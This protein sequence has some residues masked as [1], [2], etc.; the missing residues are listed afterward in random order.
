[1]FLSG[2]ALCIYVKCGDLT[3]RVLPAGASTLRVL[4]FGRQ[5]A[6]IPLQAK[7]GFFRLP[8]GLMMPHILPIYSDLFTLI[9]E[10]PSHNGI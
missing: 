3:L 9:S 6:S 10:H 2:Q 7:C 8:N 5:N 1:M 4:S